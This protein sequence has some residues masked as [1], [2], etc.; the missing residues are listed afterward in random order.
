VTMASEQAI[1]FFAIFAF[2]FLRFLGEQERS[3]DDE[4]GLERR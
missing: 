4:L 2:W 1:V 3:E